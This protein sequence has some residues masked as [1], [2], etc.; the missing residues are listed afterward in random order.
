MA[1]EGSKQ[2]DLRATLTISQEEAQAGTTR[3]LTL[4]GNR[5][6]TISIPAGVRTGQEIRIPGQ[7]WTSTEGKPGDLVLTIAIASVQDS[8]PQ[9]NPSVAQEERMET[10]ITPPPPPPPPYGSSGTVL[11]SNPAY[12]GGPATPSQQSYSGIPST[13][14]PPYAMPQDHSGY[15]VN[16]Q[17]PIQ[18]NYSH[19]GWYAQGQL[20]PATPTVKRRS[21]GLTIALIVL[22]ILVIGGGWLIYYTQVDQPNRI[23]AQKTATAQTQVAGTANAHAT[24]TAQVKATA[25]AFVNATATATGKYQQAYTQ[26]TSGQP[27]LNDDLKFR[28][29]DYGWATS[30]GCSFKDGSYHAIEDKTGY[31]YA[32]TADSVSFSNF[33]FR[34]QMNILKGDSGGL[35]FRSNLDLTKFYL[36]Q[37]KHEGTYTLYYYPESTGKQAKKLVSGTSDLIQTGTNK[38]NQ[39]TVIAQGNTIDL[40]INGKYLDSTTYSGEAGGGILGVIADS[41]DNPT[42]VAYSQAQVWKL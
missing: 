7:G 27:A 19:P 2:D 20:P 17:L 30:K 28:N 4:P 3:T 23:R 10:L 35:I 39:I 26:A 13:N 38:V 15:G 34:V 37:I 24:S 25:Q 41:V 42:E 36:L 31:F 12:A 5:S 18:T 11:A 9:T 21:P 29:A 33:A 8:R 16:Q 1:I 14:Y 40:Y 6:T 22:A 32:C